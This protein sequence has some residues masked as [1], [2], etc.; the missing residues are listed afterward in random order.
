[1]RYREGKRFRNRKTAPRG[2]LLEKKG[3]KEI[4]LK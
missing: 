2:C 4:E 1:M 3:K